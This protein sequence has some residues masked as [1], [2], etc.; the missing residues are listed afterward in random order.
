MSDFTMPSMGADMDSGTLVE[1]KVSVG[2]RVGKGQVIAAVET[3]KAVLEVEVFEDG[4]VEELYVEEGTEVPV[5]APLA[6]I[7]QEQGQEAR[8]KGQEESGK[9]KEE[10]AKSKE[11]RG[12]ARAAKSQYS[13][14]SKVESSKSKEERAE[15]KV[16]SRKSKV[17]KKS[18]E[19][20]RVS[21]AARRKARELGLDLSGVTGSGPEGSI[22]LRDLDK[23]A[24]PRKQAQTAGFDRDEMRKAIAAAMSR[25]K[26][27]IPHYYLANTVDLHAA[28]TWLDEYNRDRAPDERLLPAALFMKAAALA[29]AKHGGLNGHYGENGF[30]ASDEVH[31]GMAVHL[32]GGGLVAPAIL[33]ADH[34]ALPDLMERLRDLVQ[35]ARGGGLRSSEMSRG[36]ATVTALGERGVD[37]A[38]GVIYPP[39]VA[40]IGFGRPRRQPMAVDDGLAVRLAVEV[41]LAADHRVCDG[42]LGALFLNDIE[43]RLQQPEAL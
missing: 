12:E 31:L 26:R 9:T 17:E 28:Q 7:G 5:G 2:D 23:G 14:E 42:H 33:D 25:S 24:A 41:T 37:S 30:E 16:E 43:Q 13:E 36:T 40:M 1:W 15:S 19:G 34:L 8:G 3:S 20:V 18:P 38:W 35:R 22:V 21:P 32:R 27:E 10:R 29:L 6:R 11:E 39:Q 4:I